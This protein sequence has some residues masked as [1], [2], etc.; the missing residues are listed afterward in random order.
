MD[1]YLDRTLKT[2]KRKHWQRE[3]KNPKYVN[4]GN[5][6]EPGVMLSS[7]FRALTAP[8]YLAIL[9]GYLGDT[10]PWRVVGWEE[11]GGEGNG[12]QIKNK[13]CS[14]PRG[15]CKNVWREI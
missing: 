15:F 5:K 1:R 10:G 3:G 7:F 4:A 8:G 11:G 14:Q 13:R 12:A 9:E 2:V 6:S